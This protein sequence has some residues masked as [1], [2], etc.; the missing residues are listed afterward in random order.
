MT[1][2][3]FFFIPY[4]GFIFGSGSSEIK[5]TVDFD[6]TIR[7]TTSGE[8]LLRGTATSEDENDSLSKCLKYIFESL[9]IELVKKYFITNTNS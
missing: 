8:I 3:T 6:I 7:D 1:T 9:S 2:I 5:L 4:D